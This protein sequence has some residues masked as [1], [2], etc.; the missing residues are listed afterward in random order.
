MGSSVSSAAF[1]LRVVR[2]G[3]A[4]HRLGAVRPLAPVRVAGW[5]EAP[6]RPSPTTDAA[7][8]RDSRQNRKTAYAART[9]PRKRSYDPGTH[10]EW[11]R[12]R[13]PR[14]PFATAIEERRALP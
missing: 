2:S 11:S 8:S 14:R 1:R 12:S 13:V 6:A 4:V 7:S 5:A 10:A 3:G 9:L